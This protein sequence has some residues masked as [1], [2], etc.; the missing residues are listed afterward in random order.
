MS[1]TPDI[2]ANVLHVAFSEFNK[3]YLEL[4]KE[5]EPQEELSCLVGV[6]IKGNAYIANAWDCRAVVGR[7]LGPKWQIPLLPRRWA[8]AGQQAI[9]LPT[10]VPILQFKTHELEP[11]NLRVHSAFHHKDYSNSSKSLLSV[12]KTNSKFSYYFPLDHVRVMCIYLLNSDCNIILWRAE[13]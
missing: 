3:R 13:E 5:W 8:G 6:I 12:R 10:E 9:K 2:S 1:D 11:L 7:V 4:V